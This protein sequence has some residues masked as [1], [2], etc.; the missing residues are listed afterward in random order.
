V[1]TLTHRS[2][3]GVRRLCRVDRRALA[4]FAVAGALF[5]SPTWAGAA[6]DASALLAQSDG[7]TLTADGIA[8]GG[9]TGS[10]SNKAKAA[11]KSGS[12]TSSTS[13]GSTGAVADSLPFTGSDPRITLLLGL[14]AVLAGAG[15]R[16]RTGD[17]RD[18]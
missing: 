18:F 3:G 15:L 17:A 16:L 8:A 2:A 5:A 11:G 6:P 1:S 13:A 4:V 10:L 9:D 14:A 7:G 12:A